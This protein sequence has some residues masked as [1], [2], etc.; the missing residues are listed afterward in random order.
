MKLPTA[1]D[2]T[3]TAVMEIVTIVDP[4]IL[5]IVL[6]PD[7]ACLAVLLDAVALRIFAPLTMTRAMACAVDWRPSATARPFTVR[8]PIELGVPCGIVTATVNCWDEDEDVKI[9]WVGVMEAGQPTLIAK[10]RVTVHVTMG[11]L[12]T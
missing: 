8:L 3:M 12:S 6:V 9:I 7:V 5:A 4:L 2:A 1:T 10:V 11:S